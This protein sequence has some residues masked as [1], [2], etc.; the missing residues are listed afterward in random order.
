VSSRLQDLKDLAQMLDDGKIS[1]GEYDFVKHEL[2]EASPEEWDE[3][4]EPGA[5][6]TLQREQ[7][8][9]SG[10]EEKSEP[11]PGNM[12]LGL[13]RV[14]VVAGAAALLTLLFG[15]HLDPIAW[16]AAGI[17]VVALKST[18]FERGRWLALSALALGLGFTLVN[19][20]NM[21]GSTPVTAS[22]GSL[23]QPSSTGEPPAD[24]LGV[25][26]ED[27]TDRWNAFDAS[28][29]IVKG[30]SITP[31]S[32]PLDSFVYR[33]DN[34]SVLAGA[35]NPDDGYLYALMVKANMSLGSISN[36][37]THVCYLL[38]PGTQDCLD[39]WVHSSGLFGKTSDELADLDFETDW[40]FNDKQWRLS[41]DNN[42]ET[43]RVLA[44]GQG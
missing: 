1:Q 29:L 33:F 18:S 40:S 25:R 44:P 36:V 17:G 37:Y 8:G 19:L 7:P 26:F 13:P 39:T 4:P 10:V 14:Y 2:L 42:V 6:A 16:V 27:L 5:V 32:G 30:I 43:I 3:M 41:V 9:P 38:Y 11:V 35:Y 31:E 23:A 15:A 28:P 24:S 20:L 21:G 12:I 22:P 34:N